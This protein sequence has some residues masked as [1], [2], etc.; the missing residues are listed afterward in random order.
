MVLE[1]FLRKIRI[2]LFIGVLFCSFNSLFAINFPISEWLL[3]N[4]EGAYAILNDKVVSVMYG[5]T[6]YWHVQLT[7]KNIKLQSGK[8]YEAK[9]TLQAFNK[10]RSVN[11]RIAREGFPYDAFAEFGTPS[12]TIDGKTYT[13]IFTMQSGSV[14]NARFEINMGKLAGIIQISDISLSCL[15]C[16]ESGVST[17]ADIVNDNPNTYGINS[18]YLVYVDTLD[19]R[20][21]SMALGDVFASKL[22]L[23]VD[24]KVYG[25]V[26]A[27]KECF[28]KERANIKGNLRYTNVCTEQNN[29]QVLSKS[30][31]SLKKDKINVSDISQGTT[32]VSATFDESLVIEVGAY[33]ALY[34]NTRSKLKFKSGTY[35]FEQIY[36]EPDVKFDFDLSN[37]PITINVLNNVRFGDRN[38]FSVIGGN[39]SEI[40][41]NIV[42]NSVDLGTDGLYFGK[43]MAPSAFVRIPSR[44]H[45]VGSVYARKLVIEPQSTV[46]QEPRA[47]E[48]S[49]SEEH[50]GP[51]FNPGIFRYRSVLP[52]SITDLEMFVYADDAQVKVNGSSSKMVELV[53]SNT[54]VTVSLRRNQISGFPTEAFSANYVF[55]F[56]KNANY[57]IYWNPQTKC[58]Q[59]CDGFTAETAIGDYATVLE[60]ATKTGREINMLGGVWD[61]TQNYKDGIAP[62]KVGFEL[63]GNKSNLWD[64][65]S[66]NDLPLINLGNTAH[67]KI[68]GRSPRSLKGLRIFNGYN[69]DNGGAI[70]ASNQKI[71]LKNVLISSS[72]SNANGGALFSTDTLNLEN[73]RFSSNTAVG[74]AGAV[75]ANGETK[76]LNVLFLSNSAKKNG[77]AMVLKNAATYIGNAIFYGNHAGLAGGA[78]FN[79]NSTLNIWNATLFAN[80][81]TTANG[82]FGGTANGTIGNT[83][84]W[85]N[86]V[87]G[88]NSGDCSSEVVAGYS[89]TNSSFTNAYAG[90]NIYVGDPKFID[91]SKPSGENMYMSYDAGI[92][93]AEGSPLLKA[94]QKNDFVPANDLLSEERKTDQIALGVYAYAKPN[95]VTSFG[96]LNEEGQV[97]S[98]KPIIPLISAVSGSYYRE[99]LATSPYARVWKATIKKHKKTNKSKA[100]VK[101]WLKNYEGKIYEDIPP[102]EF[103]VYQNGEENGN[104]VF[105][106]MTKNE[107]KPIFFSKRPQ[108]A[109]NYKEGIVIHM[110]SVSDYFYYEAK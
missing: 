68:D 80:T 19:M 82:A 12:A 15:D 74:N 64:L 47:T 24:S 22:E 35:S 65:N 41:W 66:E 72:K 13:K 102:V 31:F 101:M 91:E 60:T 70:N 53:S 105:Q 81:A 6:D 103:D 83:I 10:Q 92:N 94:G 69:A 108:D 98:V 89:A 33:S 9:F 76:M 107:G 4:Y 71:S 62:W 25:S 78:L 39:P 23:G 42:G 58:K 49:H 45:L 26:D 16:S 5:G 95:K 27:A 104:Y 40:S 110:K 30:Q 21:R 54:A 43:I 32:P 106:T 97:V 109:G 14:E 55:N 52:L 34:A 67:I 84:F 63:V 90:T 79:E 3:A 86:I 100:H 87:S 36:T 7:R 37:G 51:F 11:V 38:H 93:L 57:R 29:V 17:E 46:S 2:M 75:M 77:G 28:L 48:I 20:D 8:T 73:I 44:T 59:G 1:G 50:F 99:Y 56:E 18:E 88:C 96:V 61:V 85:K